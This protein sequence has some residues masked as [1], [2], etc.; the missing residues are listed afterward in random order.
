MT[1]QTIRY[2]VINSSG[3]YLTPRRSKKGAYDARTGWSESFDDARIFMNISAAANAT[4]KNTI[5]SLREAVVIH[6]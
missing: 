5:V 3:Q 1:K 6:E 4:P 2:V